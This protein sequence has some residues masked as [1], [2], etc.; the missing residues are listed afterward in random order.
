[1][2]EKIAE[3]L[4]EPKLTTEFRFVSFYWRF[5]LKPNNTKLKICNLLILM[6]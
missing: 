3:L 5:Y 1:M 6:G 2:T 4:Q